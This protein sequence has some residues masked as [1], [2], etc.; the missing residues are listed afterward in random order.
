MSLPLTVMKGHAMNFDHPSKNEIWNTLRKLNDA[1]TKGNPDELAQYFHPNMVAIAATERLRIEGGEACVASW[2]NFALAARIHRWQET[3]PRINLYGDAAVVTYYFDIAFDMGPQKVEMRGRDMFFFVRENGRWLAV[4]DQFSPYPQA[5]AT[6]QRVINWFEIPAADFE[7]AVRFY[8]NVFAVALKRENMG[9]GLMG[10][11]PYQCPATGG[12]VC[13]GPHFTPGPAGAII[14]LDG[15]PDLAVPLARI[16]PAGG[17]IILP[18]TIITAEIGYM[19]L[20]VDTEGN[21]IGLHS[22]N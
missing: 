7:R 2:K 3:E 10:V 22:L 9:G 8:E 4:A 11:F 19:A 12:A 15:G 21:Q 13:S 1:W 14:Y 16:E 18:K 17:R 5:P 20:F 6:T